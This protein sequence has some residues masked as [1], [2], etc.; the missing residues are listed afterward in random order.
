MKLAFDACSGSLLTTP[1]IASSYAVD[2][3]RPEENLG[4]FLRSVERS[5]SLRCAERE[6]EDCKLTLKTRE[7]A[8]HRPPVSLF[9]SI[10]FRH[11]F[12]PRRRWQRKALSARRQ[13]DTSSDDVRG[14]GSGR[15]AAAVGARLR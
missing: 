15:R 5:E 1:A 6:F 14:A 10:C 13:H 2:E 12:R 8:R 4:H 3:R 9:A 7:G 11:Q